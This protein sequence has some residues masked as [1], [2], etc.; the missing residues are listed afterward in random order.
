[1]F[2][3]HWISLTPLSHPPF[4]KK[5]KYFSHHCFIALIWLIQSCIKAV[6]DSASPFSALSPALPVFCFHA[7]F[8]SSG[9]LHQ[10]SVIQ[11]YSQKKCCFF[12]SACFMGLSASG[13]A[14]CSLD[15]SYPEY[16]CQNNLVTY[17][18]VKYEMNLKRMKCLI[19]WGYW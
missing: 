12:N 8:L 13:Y 2:W 4:K 1:M 6:E 18:C 5:R 3:T 11:S 17:A 9:E 16:Y 15:D 7:C 14:F 10:H 19:N